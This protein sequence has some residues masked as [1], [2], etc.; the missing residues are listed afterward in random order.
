MENILTNL[1]SNLVSGANDVIDWLLNNLMEM[2]FYA[3]K[4]M[5][6]KD[7]TG[8]ALTIDGL[9]SVILAFA[10]SLIILKFLKKRI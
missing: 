6:A 7:V 5:L 4:T 10:V 3:E 1:L 2:C 8:V 9:K